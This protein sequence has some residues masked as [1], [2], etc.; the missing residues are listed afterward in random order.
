VSGLS[1]AKL[2]RCAQSML[3]ADLGSFSAGS[4]AVPWTAVHKSALRRALSACCSEA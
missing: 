2:Q 3:L 4:V 1:Y